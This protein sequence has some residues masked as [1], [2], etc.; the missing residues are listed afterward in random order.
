MTIVSM[1]IQMPIIYFLITDGHAVLSESPKQNKTSS[2]IINK[3]IPKLNKET[4]IL[5][6]EDNYIYVKY[7]NGNY[8][9]CIAAKDVK[10]RIC[11]SLVNEISNMETIDNASLKQRLIYYNNPDND[12]IQKLQSEVNRVAD[13]MVDNLDK[14]LDNS[15][16]LDGLVE[17]SGELSIE[18][19]YFN[20]NANKL[21]WS[22]RKR[23]IM[24]IV[25]C[26]A[27]V[28]TI[29]AIIIIILA[30]HFSK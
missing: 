29:L 1:K 24:I 18:A 10:Q 30:V 17:T 20:K 4:R 25:A 23:L 13:A 16:I 11:W 9:Y 14:I 8:F 7:I 15:E 28:V 5:T 21:K 22:M 19:S 26:I 27:V 2:F 3:I 6:H 12:K